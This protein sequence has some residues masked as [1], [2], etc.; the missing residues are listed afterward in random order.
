MFRFFVFITRLL[1]KYQPYMCV[2]CYPHPMTFSIWLYIFNLILIVQGI[3]INKNSNIMTGYNN[4][5]S[6]NRKQSSIIPFG[7]ILV[8]H[9]KTN[10]VDKSGGVTTNPKFNNSQETRR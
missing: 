5:I 10:G 1:F 2:I 4:S 3:R 9:V 6:V 8:M 7:Y